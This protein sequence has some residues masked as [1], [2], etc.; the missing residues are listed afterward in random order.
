[1][2]NINNIFLRLINCLGVWLLCNNLV[3]RFETFTD[4]TDSDPRCPSWALSNQCNSGEK[5]HEKCRRSCGLC[6]GERTFISIKSDA[7]TFFLTLQLPQLSKFILPRLAVMSQSN[8]SICRF[9]QEYRQHC[10]LQPV[11]YWD[12]RSI[13]RRHCSKKQID[14]SLAWSLFLST[15]VF[16]IAVVKIC[17]GLIRVRLANPQHFDYCDDD[18]RCQ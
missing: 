16:F 9:R 5:I 14:C 2:N 8:W 10:S 12:N 7:Q 18:Y 3:Q 17:G 15:T 4:C 6:K 1:M 11:T 13:R